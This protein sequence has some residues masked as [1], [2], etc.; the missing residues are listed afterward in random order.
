MWNDKE[1]TGGSIS[2]SPLQSPR[3]VN[4]DAKAALTEGRHKY[5]GHVTSVPST[6]F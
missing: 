5:L 6:H 3:R 4:P 1:V 2:V